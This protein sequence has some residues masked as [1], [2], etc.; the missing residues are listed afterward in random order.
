MLLEMSFSWG[1][2]NVLGHRFGCKRFGTDRCCIAS[3]VLLVVAY[4]HKFIRMANLQASH[5]V[6]ESYNIIKKIGIFE[7]LL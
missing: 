2:G 3:L 6:I 5:F 1:F 7:I 4:V